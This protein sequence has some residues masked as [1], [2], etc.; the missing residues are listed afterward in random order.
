MSWESYNYSNKV[1]TIAKVIH[2]FVCSW[3]RKDISK[4]LRRK[5]FILHG[6]GNTLSASFL[7]GEKLHGKNKGKK[8]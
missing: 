4:D 7:T 2:A 6:K 8:E 5:L 3:I 1:M